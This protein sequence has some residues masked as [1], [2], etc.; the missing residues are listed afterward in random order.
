MHLVGKGDANVPGEFQNNSITQ[1]WW[2]G[3][4]F[5]RKIVNHYIDK[6]DWWLVTLLSNGS[7][8]YKQDKGEIHHF[9]NNVNVVGLQSGLYIQV[10]SKTS[11]IPICLMHLQGLSKPFSLHTSTISADCVKF[12]TSVTIP[13]RG[14][15]F[16]QPG[17]PAEVTN[18]IPTQEAKLEQHVIS[19]AA[20]APVSTQDAIR[21]SIECRSPVFWQHSGSNTCVQ[22]C[23]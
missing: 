7:V 2:C 22:M 13:E 18:V 17:I 5:L 12:Q 1:T 4:I 19:I 23:T 21:Q 8:F 11:V 14:Q 9:F 20:A 6:S 15:S 3:S 10:Q 16:L